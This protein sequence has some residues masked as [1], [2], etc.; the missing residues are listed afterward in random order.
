MATPCGT[1][2]AEPRAGARFCD[3]C[4][5]PFATAD[6]HAEYKQVTVLFADVVHSMDIAATLGA[7][8]LREIMGELFNRC[9]AI[10][11]RYGG[12]VDKFTGD[13]IMAVFG[14]PVALEDHA[15]RA[16]RAALDIQKDVK[17]L[18]TEVEHRD[19]VKLQL[20]VGLNS[21]G[22]ITGEIGSGPLTYTA[23]GEQVGMAQR[24]ESVAPAGGVM[25]TESTARLVEKNAV[26]GEPEFVLVKGAQEPL[27]TR[28]LLAI[29]AAR[30]TAR[31]ETTFVG[32]EWEMEALGGL[33][34]RAANG[35]GSVV[36][37]VGPPGIG[38]SRMT[39]EIT[40]RARDLGFDVFTTYCESHTTDV[41]FHAAAGLLRAATGSTG[42]TPEAARSLVRARYSDSDEEDLR[43]LEDLVGIADPATEL[44]QI[45]PDARRRRMAAMINT[46]VLAR[47]SPTVYVIED[48]HWVDGVSEAMLVDFLAVVPRTRSIVLITYRPEYGGAL[49]HAPRS[50]TIALEPLDDTQMAQLSTELLGND[51][52]VT[53]L[54]GLVA[55]RAGGNPF[56][57]EEIVRDLTERDVLIGGRGC[58]L[59]VAPA[60]DVSVPSSLQAVIAA[61]IDRLDPGAKRT[62][63]A[64][65]VIGSQFDAEML[66]ALEVEL[67]VHDLIVAELIDQ[68]AFGS[69]SEFAFRHPLI[70]AVAYESQLKSDRAQL[71][72]RLAA[73]I[74]HEDQN[75]ALIA[76]HLEAAGEL[77]DAY[78]WHMRAGEWSI[79]RDNAAAQLSWERAVQVAEALPANHPNRLQ[80]RIAPRSLLCSTAFR[81]FHPDLST[82]F[83]ELRKLCN[84]AGDKASLA[85]GMAGL[86]MEHVLHGR[87]FDASRQAS[88]QMAIVESIGDPTLTVGLTI[89]ACVA[90]LQANEM[91]DVLRWTE[92]AIG[93]AAGDIPTAGFM[94]GSPMGNC[95][96][97]RG[98]A[99]STVG[100]DGW[101]KDLDEAVAM[102]RTADAASLAV[103]A[104]YKYVAVGRGVLLIDDAALAEI[105][106][107]FQLAE[108][109]SEDLPLVLVRMSLGIALVHRGSAAD[110]ARGI[111]MLAELRDT[112]VKERYAM[113]IVSGLELFVAR[114]TAAQDIDR[115]VDQARAATDELFNSGNF[116][117]CD[118]A[119]GI[120]VELLLARGTPDDRVEAEAAVHRLSGL[121]VGH[122][123]AVRDVTMLRLGAL[124]ARA[125]G[126]DST[127]R[128]FRDRYRA[129]AN[130]LGFEG[131]IALA[132]QMP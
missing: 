124:L 87:I 132:A 97:F 83:D 56:F 53:G 29:S 116:I 117:N 19:H 129:M 55:D 64:A 23:V 62:L 88:E 54:A 30:R 37:V 130:D 106:E 112:C 120:F 123:W 15:L 111:A 70:R 35:H 59:C 92:R 50:Q 71:H 33:L 73:A 26:L 60:R 86:T 90:K 74:Q 45:D 131:H 126:D 108:R 40:S 105:N 25:L 38:K 27:P 2:G 51:R 127:Y 39:R 100:L 79:N 16:C 104:A 98:F 17:N 66:A 91:T 101:R 57:A 47:N 21:G 121:E 43:L 61:R 114:E 94:V 119:T 113:N 22:V 78:E 95:L 46:A 5:S 52:S 14:A 34:D 1:C 125:R 13:G 75:A 10:V 102:T 69:R 3:A 109:S 42:L 85:I 36:G 28:R 76:E 20:R 77:V 99:R 7:E 128:D 67:V 63:N 118:T 82:R 84:E 44:P 96:A 6:S 72:R 89:P 32:R 4:G 93:L 41:P 49:A 18:D 68:T 8:R 48:A 80:M 65:A 24:M 31:I 81:R 9:S 115:A 107:A 122:A 103:A 12:T 58:Y 110:R 11:Q